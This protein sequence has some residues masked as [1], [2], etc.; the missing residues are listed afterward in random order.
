VAGLVQA[1]KA[2]ADFPNVIYLLAYAPATVAHALEKSLDVA[3]GLEYLEK[4]VQLPLVLPDVPA[5]RF[6]PFAIDR[7]RAAL[8]VSGIDSQE[9]TDLD[10]ALPL[11]A[12]LM[13]TPRDIARLHTQLQIAAGAL[14]GEVNLADVVVAEAVK[15]KV[16]G[17]MP[18]MRQHH[19]QVIAPGVARY[20][21]SLDARGFHHGDIEATWHTDDERDNHRAA[22][23]AELRALTGANILTRSPY[24]RALEFL[25]DGV[26]RFSS[27]SDKRSNYRRLQRFRFWY[28]WQC[29]CD[30]QEPLTVQ[31]VQEIVRDPSSR[32]ALGWLDAQ[33]SFGDVCQ[34]ICDLAAD[35]IKVADG[36]AWA[37]V[38]MQAE[39]R[40]GPEYI[41]DYGMGYGPFAALVALLRIDE[42]KSRE[43]A[44]R[45]IVADASITMAG[46]LIL[47]AKE[48]H[49]GSG[50]R[51][52]KREGRLLHEDQSAL[53]ALATQWAARVEIALGS[54]EWTRTRDQLSPYTYLCWMGM[55]GLPATD[56]QAF[57]ER[58]LNG[59]SA[60]LVPFFA[61]LVDSPQLE[62]FGSEVNWGVLPAA[63]LLQELAKTSDSF[64][65]SHSW[66]AMAIARKA[67]QATS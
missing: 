37:K 36:M 49:E 35:D 45:H 62:Q 4:I 17:F 39:D 9:S 53:A 65:A 29:L 51:S 58:L 56:L 26:R 12:A 11:A 50:A 13:Q 10:K 31:Q 38:F 46:R 24:E 2:V 63:V 22:L 40:F 5:R 33:D 1:V 15:L 57:A 28:R 34:Q 27:N 8:P 41:I 7:L 61:E 54:L 64:R 14:L 48:D 32:E 55:A 42:A 67:Q 16:P 21:D 6:Q 25:F 47:D 44:V 66:L 60:R 20:D 19:A 59:E 18:W 30:H 52:R 3:N 43:A 23:M